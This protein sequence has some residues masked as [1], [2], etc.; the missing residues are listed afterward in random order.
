VNP[1]S[2]DIKDLIDADSDLGLTFG[3]DLFVSEMPE[4]PDA[5]VC[6]Y[7]T[8]GFPPD[9]NHTYDHPSVQVRV[10]GAKGKYRDAY[11]RANDIK[12]LLHQT[13]NE[14]ADGSRYLG[15]FAGSDVL[16]VG[17]DDN[18]R[19]LLTV[20]FNCERTEAA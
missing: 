1:P 6:V 9:P 14:T 12:K 4:T 13:T 16:F 20:N 19:P 7:D 10:R 18:H 3:T 11:V 17:Y 2:E 8:G 15:I 5:C